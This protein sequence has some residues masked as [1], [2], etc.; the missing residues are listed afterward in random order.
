MR[1]TLGEAAFATAW[2]DGGVL[3][4]EQAAIEALALAAEH[5]QA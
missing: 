1:T 4:L 3:P 2:T 5:R